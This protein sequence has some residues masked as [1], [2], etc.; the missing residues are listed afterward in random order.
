MSLY[1]FY[2]RLGPAAGLRSTTGGVDLWTFY[3]QTLFGDPEMPVWTDVPSIHEVT[4][5]EIMKWGGTITVTV[6]KL[7][8]PIAGH[9]VTLMGGWTNSSV[10]PTVMMTKTTNAFGQVSFSL[11]S[12]GTPPG[13]LK[14]TVTQRNFKPYGGTIEITAKYETEN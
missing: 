10:H 12:S 2:G 1:R 3:T 8:T 6:R 9:H 13:E 11:P 5:P 7:G 14:V 4:H